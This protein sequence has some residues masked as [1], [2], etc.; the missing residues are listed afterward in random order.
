MGSLPSRRGDEIFRVETR[1]NT[2]LFTDRPPPLRLMRRII[3]ALIL[4]FVS[5]CHSRIW[6]AGVTV[7]THGLNGNIDDWVLD[8]AEKIPS[9][10]L[11]AGTNFTCY[12]IYFTNISGSYY[13]TQRKLGGIA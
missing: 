3:T 10:P 7:V 11:F 8:M 4:L 12:E 5:F 1:E 6:S 13:V 2:R 9:Y